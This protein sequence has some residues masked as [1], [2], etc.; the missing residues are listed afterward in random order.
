MIGLK[1]KILATLFYLMSNQFD[2]TTREADICDNAERINVIAESVV[3][4]TQ[5]NMCSDN[6]TKAE[7]K[8]CWQHEPAKLAYFIT[9]QGWYESK[10][11][12]RIHAG[13]CLRHECDA[14]FWNTPS[15]KKI[16]M[17]HQARTPWQL[18]KTFY[19][20]SEEWKSMIGTDLASTTLAATVS[21]R[22]LGFTRNRCKSDLGAIGL[23]ATG[24]TCKWAGAQGRLNG[25]FRYYKK[26]QD[27]Q[28]VMHQ[29]EEY[30]KCYL[31]DK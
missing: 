14:V 19:I 18:H 13:K 10:F 1:T 24:K 5:N 25:I 16:F 20:S 15:G 30:S 17:Y 2:G 7:Q 4:G 11:E 29:M 9:M 27:D 22:I 31:K 21:G 3:Q 23:Y 26:G 28:W 6:P 12:E 8:V